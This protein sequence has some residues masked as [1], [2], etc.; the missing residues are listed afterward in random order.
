MEQNQY[1]CSIHPYP[2]RSIT[3]NRKTESLFQS[4][5]PALG[6]RVLGLFLKLYFD[7]SSNEISQRVPVNLFYGVEQLRVSLE[8][9][10]ME[11]SFSFT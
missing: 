2:T 3:A 4:K 8:F 6:E 5:Q 11:I 1:L 7:K 9:A 10:G